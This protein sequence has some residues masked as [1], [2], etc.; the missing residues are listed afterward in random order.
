MKILYWTPLYWPE[1]G[2]IEVLSMKAIPALRERG[3]ECIVLTSHG[4]Q[5]APDEEVFEGTRIYRF[6]FLSALARRDL[7]QVVTIQRQVAELKNTHKPDL[8]HL[9]MGAPTAYF[10]IMTARRNSVPTLVTLHNCFENYHGGADTVLG[11]TF[12]MAAWVAAVSGSALED[13]RAVLPD[14]TERSSLIYNGLEMPRI[15]P[16]PLP[17]SPARIVCLGRLMPEKGFDVAIEAF[18]A[19]VQHFPEARLTIAGDGPA[20]ADLEQQA[21]SLNLT[22]AIEFTGWVA[23]AEIPLLIN[24]AT[25]VVVPSRW[26]EPFPLVA[27]EAAQMARPVVATRVGG[28]PESIVHQR[29]GL[30]VE[31]EDSNALTE[32]LVALLSAPDTARRM[33]QAGRQRM[34]DVFSWDGYLD[35]Y[36]QLYRRLVDE[37]RAQNHA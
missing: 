21:A 22:E 35:T 28:L 11:K 1:V 25:V 16:E 31:K 7:S 33:G 37:H 5:A 12:R 13:A 20:R 15:L 30:L 2:G 3:H 32:A 26:R 14:I 24:R 27:L 17:F 36:D 4:S 29:T 18:A 10:H 19:L 34:Q 8:V 6:N 23:Q 9:H